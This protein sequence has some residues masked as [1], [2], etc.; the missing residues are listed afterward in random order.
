MSR[1]RTYRLGR[2]GNL[3]FCRA[4]VG[5]GEDSPLFLKLLVDTGSSSTVLPTRILQR[6]GCNLDEPLQTMTNVAASGVITAPVVAVPWFN[7]LGVKKDSFPV[8][9]L[10]LPANTYQLGLLGMDFLREI[11]AVIDVAEGEIRLK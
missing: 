10:N 6:L 8:I 4:A 1:K 7:C 3:L 11:K 5:R 2:Q 9:A